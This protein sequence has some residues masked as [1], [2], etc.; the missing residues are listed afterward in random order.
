M[1]PKNRIDLIIEMHATGGYSQLTSAGDTAT[2]TET[3]ARASQGMQ[4]GTPNTDVTAVD[5]NNGATNIIQF[6]TEGTTSHSLAFRA[7]DHMEDMWEAQCQVFPQIQQFDPTSAATL[8]TKT[9]RETDKAWVDFYDNRI[10]VTLEWT[11]LD[12][13]AEAVG[14]EKD[15]IEIIEV[16]YQVPDV[17]VLE[18]LSTAI[19]GP[20]AGVEHEGL[21]YSGTAL[22]DAQMRVAMLYKWYNAHIL[23]N[24]IADANVAFAKQPITAASNS[25]ATVVF[26]R[27]NMYGARPR[28]SKLPTGIELRRKDCRVRWVKKRKFYRP[29][30]AHNVVQSTTAPGQTYD[31]YRQYLNLG[32]KFNIKRKM[33]WKP[34]TGTTY[35][36]VC[37][38]GAYIYCAYWFS[39]APA[40]QALTWTA[41]VEPATIYSCPMKGKRWKA[42]MW[43]QA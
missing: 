36:V 20:P 19:T 32:K 4:T 27:S 42:M 2:G 31:R 26:K 21:K 41:G 18:G 5:M 40:D 24:P 10:T 14:R 12:T 30:I 17:T 25:C 29:K 23:K 35:D 22:A 38:R 33:S 43:S 16:V 15:Y 9:A 37:P 1:I 28:K 39:C 13:I 7:D 6:Q 34:G 8:S 11:P 3:L